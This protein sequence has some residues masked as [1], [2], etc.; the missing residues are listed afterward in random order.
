MANRSFKPLGGSLTQDVVL[1]TG[2]WTLGASGAISSSDLTG[3]SVAAADSDGKQVITLD[4]QYNALV[5]VSL[6]YED[7]GTFAEA[8]S[9]VSEVAEE[10]VSSDKEI[11]VQHIKV[12]D[13]TAQS[14][15]NLNGKTIRCMIWLKN[16]SV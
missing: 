13:G 2:K 1:L 15:A 4:D 6:T 12:E 9:T 11:T 5:G 14:Q 8:E 7:S 16:S 10:T 3:F